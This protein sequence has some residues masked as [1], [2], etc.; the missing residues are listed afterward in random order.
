MDKLK[1]LQKLASD[2]GSSSRIFKALADPPTT[3]LQRLK[4]LTTGGLPTFI[5]VGNSFGAPAIIEDNLIYQQLVQN[6]KRVLMMGDDTWVQLFPDQFEK[7][8]PY[9]SFNVKDLHTVDD[10]CVHHLL[11]SLYEEDW[12]VL[13]AHFLGVDHAGHI[14]GVDSAPMIEKLEQ[15]NDILEKVIDVLKNQSGPG[16]LHENTFFLV[17]GDH[18]QTL[19]GDHGGGTAEE[20]E[21]SL[22]AMSL[23]NPPASIP[24]A[25]DSS[26]CRLDSDGKKIC[27]STIQQLDFAVT[28]A[29][30][31][32]I[33]FPFGSIGR[34]NPE[35]Y[36]LSS[37]T[38]NPPGTS[39]SNYKHWLDLEKWMRNYANVLCINSWQVKR[40]IDVYSASSVIGFPSEDL[41]HVA[42]I[43]DEAQ[44]NWS[45]RAKNLSL[46]GNEVPNESCDTSLTILQGKI[47]AFSSFLASVA[48][49]ARSKWTEFDLTMMGLGLGVFLLSLFIHIVA[50]RRADKLC[51][52]SDPSIGDS[53]ISLRFISTLFVVAIRA[54]SFLSNSY[55]LSEGKV[56]NFLLGTTGVLSLRRSIM[57]KRM[58]IEAVAFLLLSAVL[59]FTT[60]IGLSKQE[61]VS[62][63]M[64]MLGIDEGHPVWMFIPEIVPML[65]LILLSYLLLRS[66]ADNYCWRVLKYFF[67]TGTILSY[68]LIAVHWAL[69]SNMLALPLVLG[70]VERNYVPRMIYAIG[71]GQ[72]SSLACAQ[73]F[74]QETSNYTESV[75][76]KT[77][78][79]LSAW[80]STIIIIL[81]RQGPLV[82]LACIIGAWC[83]IR[84]GTLE[85][86]AKDGTIGVFTTDPIPVTQWSLL[87]VCLFFYTGH[88]CAFDGLR[89]GA[90]FIGFDEFNL[91]R[92]AILLSI[93]TFGVSH[94][95]PILG[96]PFLV[97]FQYPYSQG[98]RGRGIFSV[99]LSQVI[100]PRFDCNEL[101]KWVFLIHNN[102]GLWKS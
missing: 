34:V 102:A 31:L 67:I 100:F 83:V 37:G 22:F 5:D 49:L 76:I 9:P 75:L 88:W 3:S 69:E 52:I 26:S 18:G 97:L 84:L 12:D 38:W 55:I 85:E 29:A 61:G 43:Y 80:S 98:T 101:I 95:L 89:Y 62:V 94:I 91:I 35:L 63:F 77:V 11:P 13:I 15:Y 44:N 59:R 20:V 40:Y 51:Q 42:D 81:G 54:C 45:H 17:M 66:T 64:R 90:A 53:G 57:K 10:G 21:T 6:G 7:S 39:A 14:F 2:E 48:E 68:M 99:K 24:S 74:K 32:G 82:A 96:L 65:A 79:M 25:L 47:D 30:L 23:K 27:F 87:A 71:F 56:A 16:G 46:C 92:Q 28:V 60:E 19:N 36:S 93:D 78:A 86:K 4:G 70:S 41:R 72:L 73:F 33:P 50:I 58:L 8:Y 1:V